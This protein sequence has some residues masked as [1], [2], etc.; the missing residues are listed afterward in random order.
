[1]YAAMPVILKK[2]ILQAYQRVGWDLDESVNIRSINLFPTFTDV[3]CALKEIIQNS[4]Y[5]EEVKGNYIGSLE[6]RI[7]SLTDGL[8]AQLFSQNELDSSILFD[9]NVIVDLSRVASSETKSL[10]MGILVMKLNEYRTS[11]Q[12]DMNSNLRHVAVLEEAH[13]LLKRTNISQSME[14]SNLVGK[15]VEML[16][17]LLLKCVHMGKVLLSLINHQMHWIFLQLGIQIR[18][19]F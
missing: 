4:E 10:I 6:T 17:N 7:M 3:A 19:L 13:H 11:Q 14:S 9:Q 15:S 18:K 2:S 8:N 12:L 1:M 16:M 5:S